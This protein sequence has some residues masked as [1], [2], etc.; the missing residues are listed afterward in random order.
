MRS[1]KVTGALL[2]LAMTCF[3]SHRHRPRQTGQPGVFDYYLFVLSWSPEFCSTKPSA[4]QCS[5]HTGFIVHG[6]WPENN[7]GS[8]PSNCQTTQPPPT[9]PSSMADIMPVE[10]IGHEWQT[11]GTCSG[12]SGD[13]YFALI[14]KTHDSLK[15]PARLAAPGSSFTLTAKQLKQQFEQA[16]PNLSDAELVVQLRGN[17][18]NAVE[19]CISKSESPAP[20]ACSGVRDTR[21]GTFV[22]P[23]VK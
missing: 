20:V 10:I 23:P 12:L 18:L 6:L 21:G 17:Y 2:A 4:A 1:L 15:I 9:N 19:F 11:H 22:V 5:Q 3:P 8:Y 13:A 16:N 7:D 14:R